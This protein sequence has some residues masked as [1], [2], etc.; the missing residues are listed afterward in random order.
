MISQFFLQTSFNR[1]TWFPFP[2]FARLSYSKLLQAKAWSFN[3]TIF[4]STN[5][6]AGF[7]LFSQKQVYLMWFHDFFPGKFQQVCMCFIFMS[8]I[9]LFHGIFNISIFGGFL[10][11][12]TIVCCC[13]CPVE[14]VLLSCEILKSWPKRKAAHTYL[15]GAVI[16][17]PFPL[18]NRI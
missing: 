5:F 16:M 12:E 13:L 4:F 11:C 7:F 2:V 10:L 8:V 15:K 6:L 1:F 17:K 9:S 14:V 3:S 18:C